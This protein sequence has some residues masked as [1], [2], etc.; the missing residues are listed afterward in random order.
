MSSRFNPIVFLRTAYRNSPWVVISV[1]GHA[2]LFAVL[3]VIVISSRFEKQ[4]DVVTTV[5]LARPLELPVAMLVPAP[6]P[7]ELRAVPD[8]IEAEVVP[9][10]REHYIPITD[11]VEDDPYLE[12]GDPTGI[13]NLPPGSTGGTSIGVGADGGHHGKGPSPYRSRKLGGEGGGGTPSTLPTQGTEKAVLEGLRWLVRHQNADGSWGGEEIRQRCTPGRPCI[14]LDHALTPHFNEG[15]TGLALLSFLGAGFSHQSKQVIGDKA[16]GKR[17]Q[18]GS[19]VKNGLR[20]LKDRQREDGSFAATPGLLYND[21]LATMA[22]TEAYGL[23][24]SRAWKEPAER[25]I[26]FLIKA[27]KPDPDDPA[28]LWGWRYLSR[29][30]IDDDRSAGRITDAEHYVK[31]RDADI[32]VTCWVVMALKSAE[33][34]G[35]E[36]PHEAYDGAMAFAEWVSTPDGLAGYLSPEGA[37]QRITGRGDEFTYHTATMSALSMLVRTFSQ[38]SLE[39]PFLEAAA[40]QIVK[41]L[42]VV[43]KDKLSIDYYYWYYASLALNQFDGPDSPRRTNEYWGPWN[44]AMVKALLELQDRNAE[45]DVCSRGGWLVD[46]RWSHAGGAVYNTAINTLTLEVYYRYENAFG[47]AQRGTPAGAPGAPTAGQAG[48]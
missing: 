18:L 47:A 6:P 1:A 35:I 26:Q 7:P 41:D 29:A 42:P 34:S 31:L 39:D 40:R 48:Q 22:M 28:G 46:D 19:V 10:D 13:D 32:S 37:G 25:G 45:R 20:W 11:P 16:M 23:T 44:E 9:K 14:P 38:K 30:Q 4:D 27:Q 12:P 3:A 21:I 5:S 43:S 33:M 8:N 24:H 36:V 17:Y 2:L 15:L